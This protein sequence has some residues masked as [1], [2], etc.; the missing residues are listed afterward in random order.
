MCPA[1]LDSEIQVTVFGVPQGVDTQ[2]FGRALEV[3][4]DV[5]V[6]FTQLY[7][8]YSSI[9]AVSADV[10]SGDLGPTVGAR[11]AA[12]FSQQNRPP[13][14]AVA[15]KE[16]DV[17]K[18]MTFTVSVTTGLTGDVYEI[19]VTYKGTE[20][21]GN[22]TSTGDGE[23]P[24]LVISGLGDDLAAAVSALPLTVAQSSP[25]ITVTA[26]VAGDD[27]S[28]ASTV[29]QQPG[30]DAAITDVETTA[31]L[32][33]KTTL[34]TLVQSW[35]DF[36]GVVQTSRADVQSERLA[37]WTLANNRF[38]VIQS[39]TADI[40]D[41]VTPNL[42]NDL[43]TAGNTRVMMVYDSDDAANIDITEIANGLSSNPDVAAG[44]WYDRTLQGETPLEITDTQWNTIKGYNG[45]AYLTLKKVGAFGNGVM[46]DG[47]WADDLIM[48]DWTRARIN[49]QLADLRLGTANSNQRIPYT[50]QGIRQ[51]ESRVN[52]H[53]LRGVGTGVFKADTYTVNLPDA[54]ALDSL[55]LE[56]RALTF[57]ANWLKTGG[58]KDITVTV[59]I[60]AT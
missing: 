59:G 38:C 12:F 31:N 50:N 1:T 36:Y 16:A 40:A 58:I 27:F 10:L 25:D 37:E 55:T 22:Y 57:S 47:G 28:A 34:D 32:S 51:V 39:S 35:A 5:G 30:S 45:C 48:E 15:K 29:T 24:A 42:F 46:A 54:D 18:V 20:Y 13:D 7:R 26:N 43:K 6:G 9:S 21:T 49:E 44:V 33:V 3:T 19:K 17:A 23:T 8:L 56:S 41:G 4:E 53:Y 2:S 60:T 14:V 11:L 52:A